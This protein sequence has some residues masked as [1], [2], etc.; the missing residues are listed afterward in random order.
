VLANLEVDIGWALALAASPISVRLDAPQLGVRSADLPAETDAY[1]RDA[2]ITDPGVIALG[3]V[4]VIDE[5]VI[6]QVTAR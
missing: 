6:A 3:D 5:E 4:T 2:G 1:L